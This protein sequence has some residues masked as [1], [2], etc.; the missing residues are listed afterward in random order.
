MGHRPFSSAY[1]TAL[2]KTALAR[3]PPSCPFPSPRRRYIMPRPS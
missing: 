3:L 1:N 2:Q